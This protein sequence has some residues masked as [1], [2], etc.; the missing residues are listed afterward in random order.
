[1]PMVKIIFCSLEKI[2]EKF[3]S[4]SLMC[5]G[6]DWTMGAIILSK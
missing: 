1:M 2:I 6:N 5:K 4:V 3:E